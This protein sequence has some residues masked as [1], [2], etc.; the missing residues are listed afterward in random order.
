MATNPGRHSSVKMSEFSA[1][2]RDIIYGLE[3]HFYVTGGREIAVAGSRYA[4]V[5]VRPAQAIEHALPNAREFIVLFA[6]YENFEARTLQAFD[7]VAGQFVDLRINQHF[8]ILASTDKN[9]TDKMRKICADEPD[10]PVTLPFTYDAL[11]SKNNIGS[12]IIDATRENYYFRDLFSQ[13][14]PLRESTFFFGRVQL[15]AGLRDRMSRGENSGI[16]GLR[17][18]GKTSILLACER[19]GRT[20]GHRFVHV[21][22]QNASTTSAK[23]N[24]LLRSV[25]IDIRKE[26]GV[27]VTPV[28]LGDFS[29]L[30]AGKSFEKAIADA[31]SQGKRRT[32]VAFDEIEHISPQTGVGHWRTGEDALLFWQTI[33]SVHQ[34]MASRFSF[35]I[36]GTN[37]VITECREIAGSDN[38]MLAYLSVDYLPG[39]SDSET[40][41]MCVSLGEL[42]GM[43][44]NLEAITS[45]YSSL[46][47][48]AFLSRQVAS[49]IHRGLPFQ[50]RP[51]EVTKEHV[52]TAIGTFDF[53]PLF[54]DILSSLKARFPDEFE[55]L[56]WSALGDQDKVE[57][58][59]AIDSAFASHL[60]GYGLVRQS[61]CR[62]V[63]KMRLVSEYLRKSAKIS[64]LVK[65]DC[66]RWALIAKRRGEVE[67]G[68]RQILRNRFIDKY[69]KA[70]AAHEMRARMNK[71]R[72]EQISTYSLDEVFSPS[73][74]KL[75]FSDL[76]SIMND[77]KSYWE[78]RLEIEHATL[79]SM[80]IDINDLRFDAHAKIVGDAD[81]DKLLDYIDSLQAAL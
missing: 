16:F 21:D 59:L 32:V 78:D 77:D 31:F 45:L 40:Q 13:R 20:D 15:L 2:E 4:Y 75:Y 3:K 58:F 41:Q 54:D 29:P 30:N 47:G 80:L 39:L 5:T 68:L 1:A 12:I 52:E 48:H 18:S 23:W 49:H 53:R 43:N 35:I 6:D 55:L 57:E 37:P 25:A 34:K 60:V 50:G 56:E 7:L 64:G 51:I 63:P 28:Q 71:A 73:S 19:L 70:S 24:E 44:F 65:D 76:I 9:I 14:D 66:D 69:G 17:K 27:A 22:C 36:A 81:F 74:C 62:L 33:R 61:D 79:K 11:S 42:M 67:V 38:P 26:A 46:G 72:A 8:R 10:I